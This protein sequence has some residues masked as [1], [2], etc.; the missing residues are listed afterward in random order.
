MDHE[1]LYDGR[2]SDLAQ[3]FYRR[4][5]KNDYAAPLQVS[6][7]LP[8]GVADFV[9]SFGLDFKRLP[10]LLQRA[11]LWDSGYVLNLEN[12]PIKMY[13]RCG[14]SMAQIAVPLKG[15]MRVG[16]VPR[17]CSTPR[18]D[19][20]YR[21][22]FCNAHQMG[23]ASLCASEESS[24]L[25]HSSMWADGAELD[26]LP[27]PRIYRHPWT[28]DGENHLMFAIHTERFEDEAP[29]DRCPVRPSPIFPCRPF[30]RMSAE[31]KTRWCTPERGKLVTAWLRQ[32]AE[33]NAATTLWY[34]VSPGVALAIL[35]IV[36]AFVAVRRLRRRKK[37][38]EEMGED[39]KSTSTLSSSGEEGTEIDGHEP[40]DYLDTVAE[41]EY[42][43]W[44]QKSGIPS[45]LLQKEDEAS[46]REDAALKTL[47][48][49]Q[50]HPLILYKRIALKNLQLQS[51]LATGATGEVWLSK[52][53]GKE[54]VAVKKLLPARRRSLTDM[55][56][57]ASEV[58]VMAKLRHANV[59]AFLGVGWNTLESLLMVMEYMN[60]GDLQ[61]VLASRLATKEKISSVKDFSWSNDKLKIARSVASGLQYLHSLSPVLIHRDIKSKNVLLS[62]NEGS[63]ALEAAKIADFGISRRK[64][65]VEEDESNLT[66]T[67]AVGTISWSAPELLLGEQYSEK[68]DIYSFG[69]LLTEIDTCM[70]PYHDSASS[71]L[72]LMSHPLQLMKLVIHEGYRPQCSCECPRA[73]A[74]L[75][76]Q[77]VGART[78]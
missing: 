53:H 47:Q 4:H 39:R 15:Y 77:C 29:W 13:T 12:A 51:L 5:L 50:T 24:V 35:L 33:A 14:R 31:D 16:C 37:R 30:N 72:G 60:R 25:G 74:E 28:S 20:F 61:S 21:S 76:A 58:F 59:V 41:N 6:G 32:H 78:A 36:L 68:I 40:H 17:N 9:R 73:I 3:Q 62:M 8:A 69:V 55:Q 42:T 64:N 2:T 66:M 71:E 10:G 65:N 34:Y 56:L 43:S 70:L 26:D 46:G 54:N 22:M 1:F 19:L 57:F 75:I 52:L 44:L 48:L 45:H 49:F 63:G 67:G 7:A 23:A 38:L 11:V 18:G 27:D